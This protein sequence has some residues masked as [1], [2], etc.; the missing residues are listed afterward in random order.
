[1]ISVVIKVLGRAL[2]ALE[3]DGAASSPHSYAFHCGEA[4]GIAAAC[5]AQGVSAE[6]LCDDISDA[7]EDDDARAMRDILNELESRRQ[8]GEPDHDCVECRET[9]AAEFDAALG[10]AL[11]AMDAGDAVR[12]AL[13]I[14]FTA[15]L[16]YQHQDPQDEPYG[17][18]RDKI[19]RGYREGSDEL[20]AQ[21][22]GTLGFA[23]R[24]TD[25]ASF[26]SNAEARRIYETMFE[27]MRRVQNFGLRK[28]RAG[29]ET[30]YAQR[31]LWINYRLSQQEEPET[32]D[33]SG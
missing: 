8:R 24:F 33:L 9:P 1:M 23:T 25:P 29:D 10:E 32:G 16:M 15:G 21:A 2:D 20:L 26:R 14:G 12:Y 17:P 27:R 31:Y 5:G 18:V 3:G 11:R 7:Y 4:G 6:E 19:I 22:R 28:A 30:V 13:M